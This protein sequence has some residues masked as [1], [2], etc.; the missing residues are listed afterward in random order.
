MKILHV[1]DMISQER[2]GGSAKV[3]YQLGEAQARLGHTVA[4]FASD[5]EAEN[6]RPPK[7]VALVKFRCAA[8]VLGMKVTPDMLWADYS[9][10]D[11]IHLHNYRTYVNLA[12]ARQKKPMVLQAHGNAAPMKA[13]LLKPF[14]NYLWHNCILNRCSAFIADAEMEIE[15]FMAEGAKREQISLIPVGIDYR[16]FS[17]AP[18][19]MGKKPNDKK[20]VLFLGRFH[21]IKAPDLLIKA[22]ALLDR[23]DTVLEIAGVDY[24][25]ESEIRRLVKKLDIED[26]VRWLGPLYGADKVKAYANAD[27]YVMPSRYEMFGLTFL[28][29]LA[30]GTPVIITDKCGAAPLLPRECGQVV[31]FDEGKLAKAIFETLVHREASY[32]RQYRRDWAKQYDWMNIAPKIIEVY[33][34]VLNR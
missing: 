10:F 32:F 33:E 12:V 8:N 24:G 3:P 19:T 6:Q 13:L 34:K 11:I 23:D 15:H 18:E 5:Y 20:T 1:V 25:L 14:H 30:C 31:P 27:V 26:K 29:A 22:V 9:K 28:E 16:E 21:W 17:Y 7:G 4:I 2:A